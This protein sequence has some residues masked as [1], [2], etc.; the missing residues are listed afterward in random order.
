MKIKI[1]SMKEI[2]SRSRIFRARA[3]SRHRRHNQ[4]QSSQAEFRPKL[5]TASENGRTGEKMEKKQ[6]EAQ[7]H[8]GHL[9]PFGVGVGM[10]QRRGNPCNKV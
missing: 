2:D 10:F 1:Q 4:N 8:Q 5:Q 6:A 9:E 3:C 7:T